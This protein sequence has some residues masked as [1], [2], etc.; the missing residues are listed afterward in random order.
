MNNIVDNITSET[1]APVEQVFRFI[2]KSNLKPGD[3][4]PVRDELSEML[5]IGPRVLREALSVLEHQ[6][7]I[8]TQ[9]KA[10]TIIANPSA[11]RLESPFR[12]YLEFAGY[13]LEDM[14]RAR[15]SIEATSAYEAAKC[16]TNKDLLKILTALEELEEKAK[17][18]QNDAEEELRFHLAILEAMH[19][20]VMMIFNRLII[21][22][23][24][25]TCGSSAFENTNAKRSNAEHRKIYDAI[26]NRH[27]IKAMKL[28]HSHIQKSLNVNSRRR[29]NAT[30]R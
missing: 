29:K 12:W 6:G 18:K 23:I 5:G 2:Q 22:N 1:D 8:R 17:L 19:N 10:G 30:K 20:P 3:K 27:S 21:A 26:K 4:L 11:E 28:M 7:I 14:I 13:E 15:A 25:K 24:R 16:R 9:S